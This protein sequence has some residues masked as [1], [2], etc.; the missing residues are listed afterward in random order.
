MIGPDLVE[1]LIRLRSTDAPVLSAYVAIPP[2]PGELRGIDARL[3]SLLK[4]VRELADSDELGHYEKQSLRADVSRV[5]EV[6]NRAVELKGRAVAIFACTRQKLYEEVVLPRGVRDRAVVDATPYL[7]PLLAVL[8][9]SH[10]YGVVVVDRERAYLY[11]FYFGELQEESQLRGRALRKRNY[12]GASGRDEHHVRNKAD[13][14]TRHHF[15]QTAEAVEDLVSRTGAELLV[16]G[17]HHDT[18]AQ[19]LPFLPHELERRLAGTFVVDPSTMSPGQVRERAD[20]VVDRYERD[21]EVRL[22][23]QTLERM[24]AGGLGVGGL[25]WCLAAANEHAVQLLLVQD[26][27]QA[28]GRVC[29]ACGWLGSGADECPLCEKPTRV[30]PDVIDEM[31]A[32]VIDTGGGVEHVYADTELARHTVAARLRFPVPKPDSDRD[33]D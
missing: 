30:T 20:E 26:D 33:R 23:A 8:D 31:A 21:E 9:E 19:F 22:V 6:A 1:R 10:R 18:V 3:H 2:D 29:D 12:G 16:V 4:P 5:L 25:A 24:G 11:D 17:G 15:R 14:L 32:K 7:R 13:G 28:P 27:I